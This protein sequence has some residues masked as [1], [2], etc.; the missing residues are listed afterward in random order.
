MGGQASAPLPKPRVTR[1]PTETDPSILEAAKR[2][3]KAAMM[4]SGRMSTIMTDNLQSTIGSSGSTL[5]A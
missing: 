2:T 3:R 5:G 1:M 4:R